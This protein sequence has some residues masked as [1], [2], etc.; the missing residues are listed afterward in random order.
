MLELPRARRGCIQSLRDCCSK[1]V[2]ISSYR[3]SPIKSTV[4]SAFL[5]HIPY[6][7][8]MK[9]ILSPTIIILIISIITSI[10]AIWV[11]PNLEV[12]Y[13]G[14]GGF[15][16]LCP[17]VWV[18]GMCTLGLLVLLKK[19]SFIKALFYFVTFFF[20]VLTYF[21]LVFKAYLPYPGF[22]VKMDCKNSHFSCEQNMSL[23][24]RQGKGCID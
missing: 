1:K 21:V 8:D 5:F 6:N 9:K 2:R 13:T 12:V 24:C 7:L 17:I 22:Y 11:F 15:F 16:L 20:I 14:G 3:R 19:I 23:Q 18:L 4:N 10:S